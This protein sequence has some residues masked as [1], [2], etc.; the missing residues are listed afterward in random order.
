MGMD[1]SGFAAGNK[2]KSPPTY[3]PAFMPPVKRTNTGGHISNS[4]GAL[5]GPNSTFDTMYNELLLP[6]WQ[7]GSQQLNHAQQERQVVGNNAGFLGELPQALV[8]GSVLGKWT[9]YKCLSSC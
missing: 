2:R 7:H 6:G 1:P 4:S 9:N 5:R 3:P 8:S